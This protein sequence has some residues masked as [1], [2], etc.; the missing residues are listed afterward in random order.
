MK[1]HPEARMTKEQKNYGGCVCKSIRYEFSGSPIISYKCHCL[2]CQLASGGGA[3]SV[4]W[5]KA[6]HFLIT[7]ELKYRETVANSGRKITRSFCVNCG[8]PISAKLSIPRIRGVFAMSV[9][10]QDSFY[11]EY[12]I[13]TCRAKKMD[14]LN[15]T[16]QCF[17]KGFP[18]EVVQK[19]LE[20]AFVK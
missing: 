11:P 3:V 8:T 13:W 14:V 7:G 15:T 4:I 2:D 16:T 20:N 1:I 9:D 12:E 19:H 18:I 17:H 10:T 5:V 6:K